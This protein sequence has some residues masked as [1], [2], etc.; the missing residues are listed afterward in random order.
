LIVDASGRVLLE[1]ENSFV[2]DRDVAG[3]AELNVVR[4]A[5]AQLDPTPD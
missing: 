5:G 2:T 1:A 4:A 3:H